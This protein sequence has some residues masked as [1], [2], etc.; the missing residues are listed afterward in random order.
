MALTA[1]STDP[2]A[3]IRTTSTSGATCFIARKSSR[4][5]VP[6]IIRSVSTTWTRCERTSSS[7]RLASDAERTLIP[8]RRNIFSIDSTLDRS[9]STTSTVTA[10]GDGSGV[11]GS[12][13][14][15]DT[16]PTS[17]AIGA[18]ELGKLGTFGPTFDKMSSA[19]QHV[20]KG[21]R[22]FYAT[23]K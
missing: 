3:V 21:G 13:T 18:A 23:T 19:G 7:A 16:P 8:S 22:A 9:S 15:A 20:K 12:R 14:G 11:N 5:V 2:Y 10:S 1:T 17:E 4:P 6:G